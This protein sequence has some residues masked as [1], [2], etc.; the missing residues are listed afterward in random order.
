MATVTAFKH[1]VTVTAAA[2]ALRLRW[3]VVRPDV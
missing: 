2:K 3:H 1:P